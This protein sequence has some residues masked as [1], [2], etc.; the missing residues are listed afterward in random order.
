MR[1]LIIT[2]C[3]GEKAHAPDNALTLQDFK[4]GA[5]HI[6]NREL[7]L[8]Q[9]LSSA[10]DLYTGEQHVRLMR[11]VKDFRRNPQKGTKSSIEL[12]IL[13]AGYGLIPEAK[14]IAPYECT[15]ATMG[16]KELRAWGESLKIPADFRK[17]VAQPY[18]LGLALLGDNYLQACQLDAKVKFGGLTVLF[19]GQGAAKKIPRLPNVRVVTL[20][21]TEAKRFSCGLVGLK[22]EIA[23]RLLRKLA[24][25]R[26]A[27]LRLRDPAFDV[28]AWLDSVVPPPLEVGG[29]QPPSRKASR[30]HPNVDHVIQISKSWWN[31]PHRQKLRYFIPEW[32]DLVDPDYDFLTDTHSGGTGDWSNQVYAHQMYPEPNYDGLLMSRAVAEKSKKKKERINVLGVHRFLRVPREFPIMGDCGAFD[33]IME[34][35]PPY[36]TEDVLDYYTRLDFDYG[37]SVDHLIVTATEHQKK[38][39]YELTIHNA[40]EFLKQHRKAGLNWEPI[41]AIQGWDP[42]SYAKAAAQYVKMGYRYIALGGLVRSSST[43]ILQILHKV[44]AVIPEGVGMHLF[45]LARLK[46]IKRMADLG[47]TSVD[48]ASALR[49]A[50]FGAKDNYWSETGKH[51]RAIRVPKA[52]KSFRAKRMVND[53]RASADFVEAVE[54]KC[55]DILRSYDQGHASVDDAIRILEELDHLITPDRP[56]FMDQYRTTLVEAPWKKC[57]CAICKKDGIEVLIFRG[58]DRNRRRGF[59]N[60]YVFYRLMQRALS[61]QL[62]E[63]GEVEE[64]DQLELPQLTKD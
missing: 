4:C 13:S 27:I 53:G 17:A 54:K 10:G 38:F 44:H 60:T 61:G 51:Y 63:C 7:E 59:H 41:G 39:R 62:V 14:K 46:V 22:G 18:D 55:M 33:Y 47:V 9:F 5:S 12:N 21:N 36:T 64:G 2:S 42:E 43:E 30:A 6:R 28:L 31:K 29:A 20:S 48:S 25:E 34:E 56:T 50:W 8:K 52:G 26:D 37:V 19:C 35:K 45:G 16:V 49:Q 57:P 24:V 1:L 40:E 11:G 3:T 15:F 23:A 58:N 32:D